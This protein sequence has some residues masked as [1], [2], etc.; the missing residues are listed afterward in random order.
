MRIGRVFALVTITATSVAGIQS[1]RPQTIDPC[2]PEPPAAALA[3]LPGDDSIMGNGGS[4][5]GGNANGM[6]PLKPDPKICGTGVTSALPSHAVAAWF[7]SLTR[8]DRKA[9]MRE[10]RKV[11]VVDRDGRSFEPS[12]FTE[13]AA[14][15]DQ[16]MTR[17][18][19]SDAEKLKLLAM[20]AEDAGIA[21]KG[22]AETIGVH[23]E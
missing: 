10:A 17:Q 15:F 11:G 6:Y 18:R 22:K 7:N 23:R 1:A 3:G 19:M 20:M 8:G 4:G 9:F 13:M 12:A 2:T 16:A 5:A 14:Y 21:P